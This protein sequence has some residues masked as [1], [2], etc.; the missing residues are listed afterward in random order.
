MHDDKNIQPR[1]NLYFDS[2]FSLVTS[3]ELATTAGEELSKTD[4]F[5]SNGFVP[6]K[7][8]R[9]EGIEI[10]VMWIYLHRKGTIIDSVEWDYVLLYLAIAIAISNCE[11][12][13]RNFDLASLSLI[14]ASYSE[15]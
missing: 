3:P 8:N 10:E 15:A 7:A 12:L 1:I 6:A 14:I 13:R 9:A 11:K 5:A 4:F 2:H